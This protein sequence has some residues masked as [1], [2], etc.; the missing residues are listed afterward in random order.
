MAKEHICEVTAIYIA[1]GMIE[2]SKERVEKAFGDEYKEYRKRV[3]MF[4]PKIKSEH[5]FSKMLWRSSKYLKGP[6]LLY[7]LGLGGI[8]RKRI[9]L[10][11]TVGRKSGRRRT[12]P[13]QY[14]RGDSDLIYVGSVWGTHAD[15]YRNLLADNRVEVQIGSKRFKAKALPVTDPNEEA[16]VIELYKRGVSRKLANYLL[17]KSGMPAIVAIKREEAQ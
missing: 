11:T 13:L 15:W 14:R 10:L 3:G 9:L 5:I 16:F 6:V 7:K 4:S 12:T 17:S 8:L 1:K 2:R